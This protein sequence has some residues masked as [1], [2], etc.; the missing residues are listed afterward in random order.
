M[1]KL[2]SGR[3]RKAKNENRQFQDV[4]H[5]STQDSET[6]DFKAKIN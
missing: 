1:H 3:K 4:F 6:R 5:K 2:G